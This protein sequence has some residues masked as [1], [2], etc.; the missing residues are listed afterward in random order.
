[1]DFFLDYKLLHSIQSYISV[2]VNAK[3][4]ELNILVLDHCVVLSLGF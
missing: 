2:F 1:M 3:G 4:S